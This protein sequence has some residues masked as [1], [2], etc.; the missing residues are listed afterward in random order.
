[1]TFKELNLKRKVKDAVAKVGY[2][3][4]SPVQEQAIPEIMK[5]NDVIAC[6]Q[7][8]TGKTAAFALP[9]LSK[10]ET[11]K[12]KKIRTLV[13]TPTRE[14]AIQIFE[15]FKMYGRY[16]PLRAACIYGG[17]R[18]N[19]QI[20]ALKRGVDVLVATPGRLMDLMN[21]G[22]I[23]LKNIEIFVLDEAD[24]MLDMGFIGDVRKIEAYMPKER[25]TVM[26]SATIPAKIEELAEEILNNPISIN[27][28][29]E[30]KA[31]DTVNQ[32]I[33]FI[34]KENKI[35]TISEMLS[36]DKVDSA[37]V[38]TRT[39]HGADKLVRELGRQGIGALAIHGDKT[40]GQRQQ[41]LQRFKSGQVNILIAT[42]VA[43]RGIDIPKLG[44]VF[45]YDLPVEAE[46]YVHRIGRT[47]RAGESGEAVTICTADEM[48][49][50]ADI[51]KLIEK[52]IP[53]LKTK[54]S[55]EI[56]REVK[57]KHSRRVQRHINKR[58]RNRNMKSEQNGRTDYADNKK[59]S[60]SDESALRKSG[61][62]D[63]SRKDYKSEENKAFRKSNFINKNR[64]NEKGSRK[65]RYFDENHKDYSF[66]EKISINKNNFIDNNH[67]NDKV[68]KKE[69]HR[70]NRSFKENRKSD[71]AGKR[72]NS[73]PEFGNERHG[74]SEGG[75]KTKNSGSYKS[76]S[77]NRYDNKNGKK[78]SKTSI[79]KDR[80]AYGSKHKKVKNKNMRSVS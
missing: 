45:N 68:N 12:P 75:K 69:D 48:N 72:R 22:F 2:I 25:Q 59:L 80:S 52:E 55:I 56:S 79:V 57:K 18:Q 5:G 20:A 66:E 29:P 1:M 24:R 17:A 54:W 7:T 78:A 40:Q 38:F 13:L 15:N 36:N 16:L 14:L 26:F 71:S 74:K 47:G 50:L 51:E 60:Y 61:I 28:E 67:K 30:I 77:F 49:L 65:N 73:K 41:A 62:S 9:I 21:Q 11:V 31:A 32:K 58:I 8:G 4:L 27:I 35:K 34:E 23:D 19:P 76:R 3:E 6:A 33:C 42:D 46:S 44:Y 63:K 10:L 39:K 64:E 53:E 43:S 70:K 37:I